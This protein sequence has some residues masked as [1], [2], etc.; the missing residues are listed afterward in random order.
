MRFVFEKLF[1]MGDG[2]L[3]CTRNDLSLKAGCEDDLEG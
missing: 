3:L 1:F 2:R